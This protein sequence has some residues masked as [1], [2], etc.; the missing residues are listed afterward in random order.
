KVTG[1]K[2]I[3]FRTRTPTLA[4]PNLA[5]RLPI[6][7]LL[8]TPPCTSVL[9]LF[10]RQLMTTPLPN[11]SIII[12]IKLEAR[13]LNRFNTRNSANVRDVRDHVLLSRS[14]LCCVKGKSGVAL[15]MSMF[16]RIFVFTDLHKSSHATLQN[17]KNIELD[18]TYV[19]GAIAIN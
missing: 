5:F 8:P 18:L 10:S 2:E 16:A 9:M 13:L 14:A 12:G 4:L 3:F 7:D 1:N 11:H 19:V 6:L 17:K 15:C